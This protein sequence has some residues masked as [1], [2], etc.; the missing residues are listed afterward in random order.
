MLTLGL[1]L[2]AMFA[3]V[4]A[5]RGRQ[6]PVPPNYFPVRPKKFPFTTLREF[7]GKAMIIQAVF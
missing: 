5:G 2:L 7:T 4:A 1:L 3:P 6:F